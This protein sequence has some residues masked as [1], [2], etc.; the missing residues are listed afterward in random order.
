MAPFYCSKCFTSA[1]LPLLTIYKM[2]ELYLL[3]GF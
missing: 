2:N 3:L 1:S